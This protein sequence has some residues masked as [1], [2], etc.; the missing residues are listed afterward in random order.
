MVLK[1]SLHH[2]HVCVLF[3]ND[4]KMYG[5]QAFRFV[6][7]IKD[8]FENDVKMYGTQASKFF[9]LFLFSF[10]NDVKMYGTQA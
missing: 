6:G 4:V 7:K 8:S 9:T 1:Q 3:E 5:T 10:E 2:S